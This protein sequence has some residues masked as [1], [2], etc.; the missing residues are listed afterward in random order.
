VVTTRERPQPCRRRTLSGMTNTNL[1]REPVRGR[2]RL[3]EGYGVPAAE[4]GMLDWSWAVQQLE[5]ARNYWFSTTR[6]EGRRHAM[7]AWAVWLDDA[8]YFDGSPETRRARN[9]AVNP[10]LVVHLESGDDVVVLEGRGVAANRPDPAFAA[11]L[12]AGFEAKYGQSHD[13][14]PAP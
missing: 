4:D 5:R 10:A 14:H 1:R 13:Y 11:R 2:P 6:P 12:A 8:L 9:L 7:P 3:P